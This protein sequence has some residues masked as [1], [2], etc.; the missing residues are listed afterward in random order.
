MSPLDQ[1]PAFSCDHFAVATPDWSVVLGAP[2]SESRAPSS[3]G[4][5]AV[6]RALVRARSALISMRLDE[7]SKA[8][9][10]V[11]R[12]LS[13]PENSRRDRYMP[14]LRILE[15]SLHVAADQLVAARTVLTTLPEFTADPIV[16]PLLRY[17]DWKRGQCDGGSTPDTADYLVPPV[18]GGAIARIFSLCV[19][20]ALSFNR[21]HLTVSSGLASEALQLA[22]KRYGNH[23]AISLLPATLLAQVAYEQGR[24]E[25][26]E[27]LLRPRI[28]LIRA[29]GTLECVARA[30]VLLARL[31]LQRG[32]RRSAL[33]TLRE[34]ET[35]G[36]TRRW[37]RLV[38]IISAEYSRI[39]SVIRSE[40]GRVGNTNGHGRPRDATHMQR[41][42]A[43]L[44]LSSRLRQLPTCAAG[45]W[46]N[47][48][49]SFA[50]IE[51]SLRRACSAAA[52]GHLND[53]YG[54]LIQCLRIG[55]DRGLRMIFVDSGRP[56]VTLLEYIYDAL[57]ATDVHLASLRPYI[58]TVL[59]TAVP[60][61]SEESEPPTYRPL[62]RRETA[63]LEMIA[64]GMSNKHI[65]Q[66]LGITP[67]TVKS[68]AKSI[69]VKLDTRTR[70]QAVARAESIGLL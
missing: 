29:S 31:S 18:G 32:Q 20:A 10:Q 70:A 68:H 26:A 7:A 37:P 9:S 2:V 43:Q 28:S 40:E 50:V 38:S 44:D 65:A 53:C 6:R 66:A 5:W 51:T 39:L 14:T 61:G 27:A 60:I 12:L 13:H 21:L 52:D 57:P 36:H 19:S 63:V 58:A 4:T 42:T 8:T 55:A 30:S 54:P 41:T 45:T 49:H 34:A 3:A 25:E 62:S 33:A 22:R 46:Y 1:T 59:R 15:A 35:I 11:G 16:A 69:F 24:F 56:L 48:P 17:L 23:S 47:E 64:R 67:E